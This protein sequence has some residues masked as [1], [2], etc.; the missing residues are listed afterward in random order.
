MNQVQDDE[1]EFFDL[2]QIMWDGKWIISSL[3]AIAITLGGCFVFLKDAVYESKIIIKVNILPPFYDINKVLSDYQE[4]F[5]SKS[6]FEDWK[7][8]N[9]DT[10]LIFKNFSAI[11]VVDGYILSK[12]VDNQLATINL[13]SEKIENTIISIKTNQLNIL[14][15]FFKYANHVNKLLTQ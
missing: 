9:N 5:Y 13:G 11:E 7:K 6:I 1:I 14:D 3:V 8:S 10:L 15:A 2:F 4:K 12:N